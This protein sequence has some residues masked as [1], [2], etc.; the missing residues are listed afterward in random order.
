LRTATPPLRLIT[1]RLVEGGYK[2]CSGPDVE[3]EG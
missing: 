2:L 3:I 1:Y